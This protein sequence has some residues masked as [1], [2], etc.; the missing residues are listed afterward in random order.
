[1][2]RW[3][4]GFPK[5]LSCSYLSIAIYISSFCPVEVFSGFVESSLFA[6]KC[7]C[8]FSDHVWPVRITHHSSKDSIENKYSKISRNRQSDVP[9]MKAIKHNNFALNVLIFETTLFLHGKTSQSLKLY[10]RKKNI[11]VILE[12]NALCFSH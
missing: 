5:W 4:Y 10:E 9:S 12:K 1:M 7:V 2:H 3:L 8:F 6:K 11:L